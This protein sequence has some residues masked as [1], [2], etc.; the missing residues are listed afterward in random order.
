VGVSNHKGNFKLSEI[1]D[2]IRSIRDVYLDKQLRFVI[3]RGDS[4][5]GTL[6]LYDVDFDE[7]YAYVGILIADIKH[8]G[9]GLGKEAL[10]ILADYCSRT[11]DISL[12]K[13]D[14]QELNKDSIAFFR[15]SGFVNH[16]SEKGILTMQM[17]LD[18]HT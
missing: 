10:M 5:I 4:A 12:L 7:S 14:I 8:R 18:I 1:E 13:A 16:N 9:K 2:Y 17:E 11:L 15:S 6:D 3:G